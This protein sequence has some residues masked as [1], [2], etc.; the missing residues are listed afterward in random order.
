M[1]SRMERIPEPELMLDPEQALA[2]AEADFEEPHSRFVELFKECFYGEPITGHVL[3]LGC[4]PGDI[5]IRFARAYTECRVDGIDG[6]Q[7]MIDAGAK[8]L[9]GS[10]VADRV[11]LVRR[12]LPAEP[13]PRA[14]YDAVVSNSLLHHLHD[15]S[16]LWE[17][18]SRYAKPAAPVFIMDLM[19]PPSREA[20]EAL[21][22]EH[23]A[24]EPEVLRRDFFNSL[25]A[26]FRPDEVKEQIKAAGMHSFAVEAVSDRH[27]IAFG[28]RG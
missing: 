19:R 3:D 25:L 23:A 4:G 10:N 5:A 24:S 17:A 27:L 8:A 13:P 28:R 1:L 9:E 2:Y 16:V 6:S 20:A 7:V 15:P 12:L 26:A 11:N 18:V 22:E 21:V 14:R